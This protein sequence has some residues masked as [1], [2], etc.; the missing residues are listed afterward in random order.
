MVLGLLAL[1]Y[2]CPF[3]EAF[4][5][6]LASQVDQEGNLEV[7]EDQEASSYLVRLVEGEASSYL[8]RLGEAVA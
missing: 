7:L 5:A 3:Q 4:L 6:Y 8:E 1:P 2:P